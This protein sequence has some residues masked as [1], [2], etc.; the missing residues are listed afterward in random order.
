M[1]LDLLADKERLHLGAAGERRAGDRI[2]S[3]RHPADGGRIPF[4]RLGGDQLG[5]RREPAAEQDRAFGVD[6][7]V[8]KDPARQHDVA[9]HQGVLAQCL[10]QARTG[11]GVSLERHA[12]V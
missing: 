3:H 1:L 12:Q 9:D 2:G 7:V 6:Q 5:E 8:R 10:Q 4:T 11:L